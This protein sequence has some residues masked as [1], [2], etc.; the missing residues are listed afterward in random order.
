MKPS[1]ASVA[2]RPKWIAVLVAMLIIA[3]GFAGLAQWQLERT[4]TTV[5]IAE[6]EL[7]AVSI[8]ELVTVAQPP[9]QDALDRLVEFEAK[10]DYESL[11][12]V[13][14]RKQ[15]IDSELIDGYW[16]IANSELEFAD[17]SQNLTLALGFS[18]ELE[19]VRQIRSSLLGQDSESEVMV[20]YVEPTEAPGERQGELLDTLSLAQLVNI[21][22]DEPTSIL[23]VFV[24]IQDGPIPNG[25]EP[26]SIDILSERVEI[27]WL[28]A[29][30]AIEWIIFAL[31]ALYFWYRLVADERMREIEALADLD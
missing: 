11:Y 31:F 8:E 28:T 9:R 12:I 3:A 30:Y 14:N 16:L 13:D 29:F 20:G 10:I 4:F 23:P 5:G 2:K 22:F 1:W 6:A 21:Y 7:P 25:L 26:I 19:T 17:E 15:F 18:E 27:N 24:I